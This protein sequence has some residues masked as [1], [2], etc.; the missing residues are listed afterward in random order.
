MLLKWQRFGVRTTLIEL[1]STSLK[2][3]WSIASVD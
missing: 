3:A 1:Y 2:V